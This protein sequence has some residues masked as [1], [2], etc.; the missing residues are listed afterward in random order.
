MNWFII[1]CA[2]ACLPVPRASGPM[3]FSPLFSFLLIDGFLLVIGGFSFCLWVVLRI[4]GFLFLVR[5]KFN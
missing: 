4:G 2:V 3:G 1:Q 5:K